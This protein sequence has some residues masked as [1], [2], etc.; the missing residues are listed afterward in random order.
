[1]ARIKT[2]KNG[3]AKIDL[4]NLDT[5]VN[6]TDFLNT[7][8]RS[9]VNYVISNRALP[10]VIDGCTVTSRK[11]MHGAFEGSLKK[12][13]LKKLINLAGD[14][15]NL[16]LYMHGDM[17]LNGGIATLCQPFNYL[18]Y[19]IESDG[20]VGS[21]RDTKAQASPRYLTV[22]L[23]KYADIWKSDYDLLEYKHD[24][25]QQIEPT[26][27]LPIIPVIL[28]NRQLGLCPGYRFST[29]SYNPIDIIEAC[30]KYL[31]SRSKDKSGILDDFVIHPYIRGIKQKNW[32]INENGVWENIGEW[33]VNK[34]S[35]ILDIT[36]LPYNMEFNKFEKIL[37]KLEDKDIIKSWKNKSEGL[38]IC[39]EIQFPKKQLSILTKNDDEKLIN[40]FKLKYEKPDD[41]LWVLDENG[42]VRHFNTPQSLIEYFVNYR[43]SIYDTRKIRLVKIYEDKLSKNTNLITFIEL[44]CNGKLIIRNRSKVDI[45]KDM[46]KVHLPFELINIP[47]SKITK[48]ERNELLKENKSIKDYLAYVKKTTTTQ[49]YLNDLKDLK[50]NIEKDFPI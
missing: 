44:V 49:M 35:D 40:M 47:M 26:H 14:V 16:T 3:V 7:D 6:I 31:K 21:L 17:S 29:M 34:S 9:Y 5:E 46:D 41:L 32:Y 15:M 13:E 19:P 11:I 25:G 48:E 4:Q 23:S 39:Y 37:N 30:E 10:S 1:M 24:E 18:F 43:L 45:K 22:R 28:A 8:Y 12:G 33:K 20:Q 2:D 38:N 27:Y 42:K 50:H 36:D